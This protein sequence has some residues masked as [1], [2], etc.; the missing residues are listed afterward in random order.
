MAHV[1]LRPQS[2]R[3]MGGYRVQ[4]DAERQLSRLAAE[5]EDQRYQTPTNVTWEAFRRRNEFDVIV[6]DVERVGLILALLFRFAD[7]PNRHIMICHGQIVKKKEISMVKHL[8]LLQHIHRFVCYGPTMSAKL[9]EALDI[10]SEQ[11]VTVRHPADH[12]FWR[13][14]ATPLP[15][16]PLIVSAGLLHRDYATLV[17]AVRGLNVNVII[18]AFSPSRKGS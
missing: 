1:G 18:A 2:V 14:I 17:E 16:R 6:T 13:P 11:V 3:Q 15:E 4:R 10:S 7:A 12:F 8:G 9:R 5:L